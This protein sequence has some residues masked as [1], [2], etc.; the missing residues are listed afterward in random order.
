MILYSARILSV[1]I[2][3]Q[4]KSTLYTP[5]PSK[6]KGRV[7]EPNIKDP[8]NDKNKGDV[9]HFDLKHNNLSRQFFTCW[10]PL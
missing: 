10:L 8:K 9:Y 3:L 2:Q 6:S 5:R 1:N 4:Y 7:R